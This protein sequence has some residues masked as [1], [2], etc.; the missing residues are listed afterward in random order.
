MS[1]NALVRHLQ[2][3]AEVEVAS[4]G[5]IT[6]LSGGILD[7]KTGGILFTNGAQAALIADITDSS[8]GTASNTIA[9]IGGTYNQAEVR[10]A[11]ASLAAKL[12]GVLAVLKNAGI[13]AST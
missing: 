10:N 6:I 8:G 11:V 3:G 12:N 7:I 13:I 1:I 2:G 9:A 5:K 4:G